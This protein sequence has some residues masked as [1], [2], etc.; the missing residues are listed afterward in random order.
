M[1]PANSRVWR[2]GLN[3]RPLVGLIGSHPEAGPIVH[4]DAWTSR[5]AEDQARAQSVA[6]SPAIGREVVAR[7]V[8]LKDRHRARGATVG[9]HPDRRSPGH[10][11][12]GGD[13]PG[14]FAGQASGHGRAVRH[15]HHVDPATVDRQAGAGTVSYTHLTLPTIYSV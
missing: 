14:L 10:L 11:G 2:K 6:S 13:P 8:D 5:L 1:P 12:E 4:T 15:P 9:R 7:A 3:P